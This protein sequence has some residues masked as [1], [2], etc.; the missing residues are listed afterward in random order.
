M[1]LSELQRKD[2]VSIRDGKKI[3]KII[4][5]E[6]D[7][8]SGYMVHFVIEKAHFVRNLFSTTEEITINFSQIK[9]LGEDVI[10]IDIS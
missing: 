2:I 7:A 1:K 10:L 6:F 8:K 3:G 5:V 9:K 4:D